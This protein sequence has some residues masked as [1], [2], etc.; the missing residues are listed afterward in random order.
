M[1]LFSKFYGILF[2]DIY[3]ILFSKTSAMFQWIGSLDIISAN[4][5]K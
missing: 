1:S 5:Y 2:N 4:L 3:A